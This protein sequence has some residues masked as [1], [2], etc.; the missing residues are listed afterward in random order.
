MTNLKNR[1]LFFGDNLEILRDKIPDESFDLI[2]LDPPFNS[3]R[4]YNVLFKEGLQDSPAQVQAFE[5]SWHWTHESQAIFEE[6]V[7]VR[8]SPTK[9]NEQ[10]SNLML[11]LEKLVGHNDMLAYLTMMTVRL[12]ELRRVLKSTGSIY[13][14]CDPTASHYLKL[15][16]DAIFG[17]QNFRNEIV[18]TYRR[19]PSKSK[20][21]QT[22]HDIILFYVKDE[23]SKYT[24]NTIFQPLADITLKI[25]KGRKQL[26][27]IIDG[28]RLS[29][30]QEETSVGTP[31]P[32][33]WYIPAIAGN[34]KERLGY[35]TQKPE[36]LLERIIEV[37]S[38]EGDLVLDPFCGCGTTVSVAE[39]LNRQWVGIDITMLA[40]NL[41]RHR[42]AGQFEGKSLPI[43]VDGRPKDVSGAK[44][45]FEKDPFE[46]EYWA[47][48]LVSAVPGQSKTKE[49]MR[50]ADKGIDGVI[51][52]IK[53]IKSGEQ[54]YGRVLVQVKGGMVHRND[55]A[56]LKGDIEREK[57]DGG[58]LVTLEPSTRPMI[59]EAVEAG[60]FTPS[61][62]KVEYPKIQ[63]ISVQELIAGKK[64]A[65]PA[66]SE[67][68]FKEAK[69][70][71]IGNKSQQGLGI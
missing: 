47:L 57:A 64:P 29:R 5:D 14:H 62:T 44:A 36:Q 61:F 20:F 68:Y 41:I 24:F 46:F 54:I 7:G 6:L 28:K 40:I 12:I 21:F 71:K 34:A 69:K 17:K 48:D 45:L 25:H 58:L 56:T 37:S 23:K 11:A 66:W 65:L 35:P 27:T 30:D 32:D 53:D 1:T 67:P 38:N 59:Q 55:I 43:I 51:N 22:M 33:Y 10:I 49:N 4:N 16:M 9:I 39:R 42:L 70:V 3:N 18:W 50:G 26:A 2:Y 13:L 15:V 19:W 8:K 31:I 63:I 52:F 60:T